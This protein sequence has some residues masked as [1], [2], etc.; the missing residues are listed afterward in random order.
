MGK[1]QKLLILLLLFLIIFSCNKI[2]TTDKKLVINFFNDSIYCY[3]NES[4]H[5][6]INHLRFSLKNLSNKKYFI[7]PSYKPQNMGVQGIYKNN[8]FLCFY[9]DKDSLIIPLKYRPYYPYHSDLFGN[10][11]DYLQE[12]S[13][14]LSSRL[15]YNY[16]LD[17]FRKYDWEYKRLIINSKE[18]HYFE[19]PINLNKFDPFDLNREGLINLNKE[20]EYYCKLILVSDSTNYKNKLPRDILKTLEAN[21]IEVYHGIIESTTKVPIKILDK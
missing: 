11:Y 16:T 14:T 13:D 17:Y 21:N 5:D 7:F 2:E 6:T 8:F 3:S 19:F 20:K 1:K 10:Y 15:R 4:K 9:D 18:E 12:N